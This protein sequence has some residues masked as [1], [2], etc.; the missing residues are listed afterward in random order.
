[1]DFRSCIQL[2]QTYYEYLEMVENKVFFYF[3]TEANP[4]FVPPTMSRVDHYLLGE[5][6][7]E[8][9]YLFYWAPKEAIK[10][11][12]SLPTLVP[13]ENM[14]DIVIDVLFSSKNL[15][16]P[17][18]V[19]KAVQILYTKLPE[20][21]VECNVA[22]VEWFAH[23]LGNFEL[24]FHGTIFSAA[25]FISQKVKKSRAFFLTL[26]FQEW[27]KQIYIKANLSQTFL[28]GASD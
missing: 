11:I 12:Q 13:F 2:P 4:N 26:N 16:F 15:A 3:F 28:N 14:L 24:N 23:H 6:I 8:I 7:R 25:V 27:N 17:N 9:L 1:M 18:L 20:T 10:L 22:L 5:S 21:N 19:A